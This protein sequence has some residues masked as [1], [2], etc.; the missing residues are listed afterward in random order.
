MVT[1]EIFIVVIMYGPLGPLNGMK[2]INI[3]Y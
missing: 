1:S 3:R 2:N